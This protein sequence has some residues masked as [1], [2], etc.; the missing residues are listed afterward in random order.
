MHPC[1][2]CLAANRIA[3][4]LGALLLPTSVFA[5]DAHVAVQPKH[6]DIVLLRNVSTRPA[7]RPA[8]PG[9]ALMV[10]PSPRGEIAHALGTGELSDADFASLDASTAPAGHGHTVVE[11]MVGTA[12]GGT[13][14]GNPGHGT[15]SGNG[16]SNVI[17]APLGTVGNTTRGIGNQIVGAL[18]QLP[19]MTSNPPGGH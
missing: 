15:V 13:L 11:Q 17:A 6:G 12:V 4:L 7:Y 8:P 3:L 18:S 9:V 1:H 16:V 10:D 14:G 19:M 5:A 2:L